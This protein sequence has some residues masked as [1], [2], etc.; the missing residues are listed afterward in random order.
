MVLKAL[1]VSMC[2]ACTS[3]SLEMVKMCVG[4]VGGV[5]GIEGIGIRLDYWWHW[6]TLMYVVGCG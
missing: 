2:V 3:G 5:E 1:V 4:G 6:S